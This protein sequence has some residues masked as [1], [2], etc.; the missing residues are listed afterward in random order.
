MKNVIVAVF[1]QHL[2]SVKAGGEVVNFD[3]EQKFIGETTQ[4][5]TANHVAVWLL[6]QVKHFV[7][8]QRLQGKAGFKMSKPIDLSL[9][10]NKTTE[11]FG[12]KFSLNLERLERLI[13][14]T[15][16]LVQEAFTPAKTPSQVIA[17]LEGAKNYLL[18]KGNVMICKA[19]PAAR[20]AVPLEEVIAN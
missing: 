15:P 8:L 12:F 14:R 18:E 9:T 2:S 7:K 16:E 6:G 19:V 17:S 20:I 11:R 3:E 4:A 13:E 1:S 10:V 5:M